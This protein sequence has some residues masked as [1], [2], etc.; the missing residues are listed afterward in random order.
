MPKSPDKI[1]RGMPMQPKNT[2]SNNTL[3]VSCRLVAPM[4]DS[5]PNCRVRSLTE[6]ENAL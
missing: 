5:S 6:M 3:P 2:A 1:P 4:E